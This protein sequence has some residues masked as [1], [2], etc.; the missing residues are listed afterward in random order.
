MLSPGLR[1]SVTYAVLCTHIGEPINFLFTAL[2]SVAMAKIQHRIAKEIHVFGPSN[3]GRFDP[4]LVAETV[5]SRGT[6]GCEE[7]V[8]AKA[9][10]SH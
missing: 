10:R 4:D 6:A 1:V 5:L 2:T 3:H 8:V 7:L 9:S